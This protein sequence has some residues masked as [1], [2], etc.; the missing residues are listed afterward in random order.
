M[1]PLSKE[2]V[3]A[4][5][6]EG[7][8]LVCARHGPGGPRDPKAPCW[9]ESQAPDHCYAPEQ[10]E[11]REGELLRVRHSDG[12]VS[13]RLCLGA[14]SIKGD[15]RIEDACGRTTTIP[16]SRVEA[17]HRCPTQGKSPSEPPTTPGEFREGDWVRGLTFDPTERK[18]FYRV[19]H[20]HNS[21]QTIGVVDGK[22]KSWVI[23]KSNAELI[24][25]CPSKPL[26]P[27]VVGSCVAGPWGP[28]L[29]VIQT[30]G[31]PDSVTGLTTFWFT[32]DDDPQVHLL[33]ELIHIAAPRDPQ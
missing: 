27:P 29:R 15:V 17:V 6:E 11:F 2:Y 22:G 10:P 14:S 13:F 25:R 1:R 7:C 9:L 26:G 3:R 32:D 12:T 19:T 5:T 18:E 8:R 16:A 30:I 31:L 33:D 23:A 4:T 24:H 20:P 21:P 28:L